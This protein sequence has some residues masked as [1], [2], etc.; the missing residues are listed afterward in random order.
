M[1]QPWKQAV[2]A[3]FINIRPQRLWLLI[4]CS[5]ITKYKTKQQKQVVIFASSRSH[6]TI[7]HWYYLFQKL[8]GRSLNPGLQ[9]F[10]QSISGTVDMDGNGYSGTLK[11][12]FFNL[13]E[14]RKQLG[15]L[16][17]L[18][19][20]LIV[21]AVTCQ[22]SFTLTMEASCLLHSKVRSSLRDSFRTSVHCLGLQV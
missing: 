9:M 1:S 8:S 16:N 12:S 14:K 20:T 22:Q 15:F 18:F 3:S 4:I 17:I 11:L 6:E 5:S 10:G 19:H 21:G 7:Q 2:L 13:K